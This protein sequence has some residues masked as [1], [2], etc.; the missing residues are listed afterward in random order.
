MDRTTLGST[1]PTVSAQGLGCMGMSHG[2]G[3]GDETESLAVLRRALEIAGG[4]EMRRRR[5]QLT[6]LDDLFGFGTGL[7]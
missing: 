4:G 5:A 3:P 1:G 6:Q 7:G 2:Y